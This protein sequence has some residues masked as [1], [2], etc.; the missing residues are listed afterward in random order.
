MNSSFK[1]PP[2]QQCE[3]RMT[4]L[5]RASHCL[6]VLCSTLVAG[7]SVSHGADTEQTLKMSAEV[8]PEADALFHRDPNWLG[9]DDAYSIDLGDERVA[10]FFGDSFV[11]PTT[12]GE[13]RGTTMVHNSVGIQTGYDP[14]TADFKT[15]WREVDGKQTSF[16][17]DDGHHY[18]WPGGSI[19]IDGKL[20]IFFMQSWTKDPS[21]AMGFDTDGWA[22]TLVDNIK[23]SPDKWRLLRLDAP[24]NELGV[25]VGS[26]AV[27]RDGE[28]IVAFSVGGKEHEVYLVR[29]RRADAA[30]G[31][32]SRPEWWAGD[33]RGWVAQQELK[34]PPV[35]VIDQAQ[36]EF[37]VFYSRAL[38]RYLQFQFSGFPVSPIC[39]RTAERLAGPWSD[40]Q[41][42]ISETALMPSTPGLM[43][44]AVKAHPE[45]KCDGLALTYASNTHKLEQLLDSSTIY[46]PQFVRVKL[47]SP[48]P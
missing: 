28:Y 22:A 19:K 5:Q 25:L 42:F 9:G 16:F 47:Q 1:R 27:V 26:A 2:F 43:L 38:A 36:T 23:E 20:L 45:L 37:S 41:A 39:A 14:T 48:A 35:P 32:L 46:Y 3:I 8:W 17:P 33:Q 24:Q 34:E 13:R 4:N 10:W 6:I 29:W 40:P 21:H 7:T 44:Y 11:A 31:D 30:Q 18:F 15:Y 12:P